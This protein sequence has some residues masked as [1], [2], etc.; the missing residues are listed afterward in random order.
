MKLA[1]RVAVVTGGAS[2]IGRSV[3]EAL[4]ARG[5]TV[6]VNYRS[7]TAD[8][9]QTLRSLRALAPKGKHRAARADV[10]KPAQVRRLFASVAK[11]EGRLDILVNSAGW[12]ETVP[13]VDLDGLTESVLEG[14]WGTNVKGV[15][16]CSREAVKAMRRTQARES[17]GW[18]G[19][20][21]N[22]SSNAVETLNAS[23]L[24]YVA[25]KAAVNS[26]TRTFAKTF[27]GICRV[28]AVA[29]GLNRTKLTK[30]A[31][32]TRFDRVLELTPLGRL[33]E[34]RDAAAAVVAL[35]AD[36][37]FVSGQIVAVDGGRS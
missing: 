9:E 37:D 30:G 31:S 8:A 5:A 26:L 13:F 1:G 20:I 7:S 12:T 3:C 32:P 18:R 6:V 16:Y 2:G 34:P 36:M 17:A 11:T 25:S 21:V 27:G 23:N 14:V 4:A 28:N 19:A 29:P 10:S 35:A 15:L 33:S 22:V 24:M